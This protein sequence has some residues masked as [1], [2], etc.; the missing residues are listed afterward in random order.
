[1][2][3]LLSPDVQHVAAGGSPDDRKAGEDTG[4]TE[5]PEDQGDGKDRRPGKN[6]WR[7][8]DARRDGRPLRSAQETR[9]RRQLRSHG[10]AQGLQDRRGDQIHHRVLEDRDLLYLLRGD[11]QVQ[12]EWTARRY[13]EDF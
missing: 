7:N 4:G 6:P 2:E 8:A 12:M 1:M 11:E 5:G 9:D 10:A 13:K 3:R